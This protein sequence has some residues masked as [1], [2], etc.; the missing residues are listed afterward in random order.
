[1][2]APFSAVA[3]LLAVS[4]VYTVVAAA[5]REQTRELAI[6]LALGAPRAA[7][8]TS[9]LSLAGRL[10]ALGIPLGFLFTAVAAPRLVGSGL[11]IQD[12][13]LWT[14]APAAMCFAAIAASY[15]KARRVLAIDPAM[16]LRGD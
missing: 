11:S 7:M 3:L 6:R 12:W 5:A 13:R 14:L 4:G 2:L 1:M 8:L 9:V 16:T 15:V 10:L